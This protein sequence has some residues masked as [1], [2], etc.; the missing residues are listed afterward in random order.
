MRERRRYEEPEEHNGEPVWLS[1][2]NVTALEGEG[3]NAHRICSGD[4]YW[5]ERFGET[6]FVSVKDRELTDTLVGQLDEW[7]A[8]TNVTFKRIYLRHLVRQPRE[9]D[10]PVLVRGEAGAE[11]KETVTE[12]GLL[13]EVDFAT[14]Y[15]VG[16]F[17]DQRANRLYLRSLKP[18]RVLNTFAY[19][20]AFS[21]AG[22]V[23]GAETL[24]IDLSKSSLNRGRR[25]F[26][27][28]KIDPSGHRFMADD[29]L[30]VLPRLA[31]RE[32]KFDA[33]ILDPP[34]FGRS[35]P[36]RSFRAERDYGDLIF[37]A[38]ECSERGASILLST[39]CTAL[40]VAQLRKIASRVSRGKAS[41]YATRPLP[42][43]P[44]RHGA[45]T[46]WMKRT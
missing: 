27:L 26:E 40:D 37:H 23:E 15:S 6:A 18:K 21:V 35:G 30:E 22:A 1:D 19:T 25:N 12:S 28:N 17:C 20:C 45:S 34:T 44:S 7:A 13:Y 9:T 38:L 5:I 3:T 33:I 32:E 39:N 29:V 46:L 14:S 16:L 24:S 36:K 2:E 4:D 11:A 10:Q 42:D 41:F 8:S 31:R 43:I